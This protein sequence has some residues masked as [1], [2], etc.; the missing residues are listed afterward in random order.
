MRA[1]DDTDGRTP[2]DGQA[3]PAVDVVIVSQR[4]D[5]AYRLV[6]D[7][8]T[9]PETGPD[10]VGRAM[11]EAGA[12]IAEARRTTGYEHD[13]LP[14]GGTSLWWP[15]GTA[16]VVQATSIKPK[17]VAVFLASRI[18][19]ANRYFR[20]T[21]VVA[22][23]SSQ[24]NANAQLRIRGT[25]WRDVTLKIYPTPS[26]NLTVIEM[27]PRRAWMPQTKRYLAAG[28]PAIT[29][30]KEEVEAATTEDVGLTEKARNPT[31]RRLRR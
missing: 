3:M 26:A 16:Q 24:F 20:I 5:D 12:A 29:E 13:G 9:L 4:D 6:G 22:R 17:A 11:A 23:T 18:G 15:D 10:R 31:G 30:L 14:S 28:V 2:T 25:G 21:S 27:M 8:E 19:Q 7:P 1:G